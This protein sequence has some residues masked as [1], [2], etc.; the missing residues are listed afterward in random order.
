MENND[1][2]IENGVLPTYN[3]NHSF[4]LMADSHSGSTVGVY[5]NFFNYQFSEKFSFKS[6]VHV[7]N[8]QFYGANE[9]PFQLSY[10]LGFSYKLSENSSIQFNMIKLS[11]PSFRRF[12]SPMG[13][14]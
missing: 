14:F 11:N 13:G 9:N 10:D 8:N 12:A 2:H 3:M 4:S 1:I 7:M 6:S 5:S